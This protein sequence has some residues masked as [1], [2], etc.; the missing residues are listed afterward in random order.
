M[1]KLILLFFIF[2]LLTLFHHTASKAAQP[3]SSWKAGTAKVK[4]TPEESMWMAGYAFRD[5][6]SEGKLTD[7]WAKALVLEDAQGKRAV[8]IS[9]DLV[10]IRQ[11]I[12][13]P[14]RNRIE[15]QFGLNRSQILINAS[16]THSGPETRTE[17]HIVTLKKSELDKIDR[18]AKKLED[19]L[20][21]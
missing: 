12:S 2:S 7:L 5:H 20:V 15:K 9:T 11:V 13:E 10:A 16:H 4:I 21:N 18:Y 1:K 6:P 19:Q 8:M 3:K 14:V 17:L